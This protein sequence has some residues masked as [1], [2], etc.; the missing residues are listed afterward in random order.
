MFKS[1]VKFYLNKF[2]KSSKSKSKNLW[3]LIGYKT[4]N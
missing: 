1:I 2:V 3:N 4:N